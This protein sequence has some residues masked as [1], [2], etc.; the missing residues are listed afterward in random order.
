MVCD[1]YSASVL[2]RGVVPVVLLDSANSADD[3]ARA[4]L[5]GGLGVAEV[6]LRTTAAVEA[7]ARLSTHP[8]LLVG[9]GTV[10]TSDQVDAVADAGARFIVSPGLSQT[11][12][13]RARERGL[14]VM[15]GVATP[16][17]IMTALDLGIDVVKFFPASVYGG[18]SAL[19]AFA[20]PFRSMRFVPTGGITPENMTDYLRLPNVAAVGGT[21]MVKPSLIRDGEFDQITELIRAA[22]ARVSEMRKA[23]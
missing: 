21:W 3:L 19:E 4:L 2:A 18:I 9:A 15:P 10:L 22:V 8:D 20:S 14:T 6:T 13:T 12:I 5:A 23:L 17:E 16:S 11:V 7:I 1:D